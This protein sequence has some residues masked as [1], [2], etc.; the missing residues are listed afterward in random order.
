ML[1]RRKKTLHENPWCAN[2]CSP[3]SGVPVKNGRLILEADDR[4][5]DERSSAATGD[6]DG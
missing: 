3:V 1:A 6:A 2:R 4:W 5:G